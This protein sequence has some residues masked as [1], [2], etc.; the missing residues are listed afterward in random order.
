ML[1]NIIEFNNNNSNPT[2]FVINDYRT[3]ALLVSLHQQHQLTL[4]FIDCKQA[5]KYY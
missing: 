2:K 1:Q 4:Q 3:S 5:D